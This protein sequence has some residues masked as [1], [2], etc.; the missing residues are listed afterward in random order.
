MKDYHFKGRII[1]STHAFNSIG[2]YVEETQDAQVSRDNTFVFLGR[3]FQTLF[4][5]DQEQAAS[6]GL[7]INLAYCAGIHSAKNNPD[8]YKLKEV[9]KDQDTK[10]GGM[11]G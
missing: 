3:M 1:N 11:F 7:A 9:N 2:K 8:D 10:A 4:A 6:F 5:N